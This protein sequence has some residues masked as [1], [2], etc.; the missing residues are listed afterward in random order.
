MSGGAV[1][2]APVRPVGAT[3]VAVD[4]RSATFETA[5]DLDSRR[6]G[7]AAADR[8]GGVADAI[9]S[10]RERLAASLR[11]VI[12]GGQDGLVNVLGLVLGMAAAT[13]DGRLVLT[14]GLAAMLAESIAMAGVAYTA[15]AAER[16]WLRRQTEW[17]RSTVA[18]RAAAR[19]ATRRRKLAEAGWPGPVLGLVDEVAETERRAWLGE[20]DFARAVLAPVRE[21]QPAV[22]A[23]VVGCSTALGSAVPLLPFVLLP[24]GPAAWLALG[25]GAS[26]LFGAGVVRARTVGGSLRRAGM[27]MVLIGLASAV[28]GYLI[29][30]LLRAP[31][32]AA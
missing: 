15:T 3:L 28:A 26:V 19:A 17:V 10:T 11:D 16:A 21:S 5:P 31:A 2:P 25:A 23:L 7:V 14:A 6:S 30:V 12:L 18:A 22:A 4:E 29:G 27:E 1:R 9:A 8:A 24:P 32:V 20:L 13:G